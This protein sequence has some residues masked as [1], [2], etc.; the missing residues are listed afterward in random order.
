M[1]PSHVILHSLDHLYFSHKTESSLFP[2]PVAVDA[3]NVVGFIP[4]TGILQ[5]SPETPPRPSFIVEVF[6]RESNFDGF[7]A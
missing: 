6:L 4:S 3:N 7:C 5:R 1:T 2:V